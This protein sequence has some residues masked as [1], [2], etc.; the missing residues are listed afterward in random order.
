ML[1]FFVWRK[2]GHPLHRA[3]RTARLS[4]HAPLALCDRHCRP[5]TPSDAA[6]ASSS[7]AGVV[8][9]EDGGLDRRGWPESKGLPF[10]TKTRRGTCIFK[11][12]HRN[13][14]T[15]AGGGGGAPSPEARAA[16]P[17]RLSEPPAAGVEFFLGG[18][19]GGSPAGQ[20]RAKGQTKPKTPKHPVE[21]EWQGT[22][23]LGVP[24]CMGFDLSRPR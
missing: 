21:V 16:G 9:V 6:V 5:Y 8:V 17:W 20:V 1:P 4:H 2:S 22:K 23:G 11:R 19:A 10:A 13:K 14:A 12:E 3:S 7:G 18:H 24:T 15:G